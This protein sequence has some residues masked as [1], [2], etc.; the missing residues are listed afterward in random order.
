MRVKWEIL[1]ADIDPEHD[2]SEA[3]VRE[4]FG[5]FDF[6]FEPV[7]AEERGDF[8]AEFLVFGQCFCL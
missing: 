5:F 4:I 1:R 3:G 6:F 7:E 2:G 8:A